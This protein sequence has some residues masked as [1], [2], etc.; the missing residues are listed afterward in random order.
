MSR[1]P[2]T[3]SR[4][5]PVLSILLLS[6]ITAGNA[7]IFAP[8]EEPAA[9][10][11]PGQGVA[12]SPSPAT[13]LGTIAGATP[14]PTAQ[15]VA[16]T[17]I[18]RRSGNPIEG[19]TIE[20]GG[21]SARSAADGAFSLSVSAPTTQVKIKAPGYDA[22]DVAA[23]GD[24][25]RIEL[26]PNTV[27]GRVI[28][29]RT[30]Q[31]IPRA[32]LSHGGQAVSTDGAG[33]FRLTDLPPEAAVTVAAN[34]YEKT[35]IESIDAPTLTV[36]LN[37]WTARGIYATLFALAEPKIKADI[38]RTLDSG[39]LNAIV[40]DVKGDRA[41]TLF[42]MKDPTAKAIGAEAVTPV[43]DIDKVL[44]D[45]KQKGI[46]TI[47][48]VVVFKDDLMAR[49]GPKVGRD[50]AIK[51]PDGSL[52]I[53]LESQAWVDP[54]NPA[55]WEYPISIAKEAV[56]KGFDEVQFD[57]I[58]F[59]TDPGAGNNVNAAVYAK[60]PTP[61]NRV[62]SIVGFLK[63][64]NE[65]LGPTGVP[66]SLD[67]FGYTTL[68]T[69]DTGI[70]QDLYVL[71][72]YVDY[73]SPM[74]YPS[75][76]QAGLPSDPPIEFPQVVYRPYEVVYESI[77]RVVERTEGK[78]AKIRPWLQYF[79]DYATPFD[80]PYRT[81]EVRAQVQA[82]I[83]AGGLGWL[84]WDPFNEYESGPVIVDKIPESRVTPTPRP[85]PSPSPAASPAAGAS[86]SAGPIIRPAGS[87]SPF[88][89]PRPAP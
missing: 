65:V 7:C 54:S 25:S 86:P 60:P 73:I 26:R 55:S 58:R 53:D 8:R 89:S 88:P 12:A 3:S 71:A 83:D 50:V 69:D 64:A 75:T 36:K 72:D 32:T 62:A 79:D 38:D 29:A 5:V 44:A 6:L 18:D 45:Y 14:A 57:Y 80:I 87:P 34:G 70:G 37:Q 21:S 11:P 67:T 27:A 82:T 77:R 84:Y 78:R 68:R 46:Y 15:P 28:D 49:N 22:V 4:R 23:D 1:Q 10:A 59:P 61:E 63:R 85:S 24:L 19:A 66:I 52:W 76:Y 41:W 42:A 51:R 31:P 43:P 74:V 40:I 56:E 39:M 30:E 16:G 81:K 33:A 47:A 13:E 9:P 48:R 17:V 35:K 2:S 20:A